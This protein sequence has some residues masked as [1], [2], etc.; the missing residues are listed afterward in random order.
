MHVCARPRVPVAIITPACRHVVCVHHDLLLLP[1][2]NMPASSMYWLV[3]CVGVCIDQYITARSL[4]SSFVLNHVLGNIRDGKPQDD[5]T[6]RDI[7]GW[8]QNDNSAALIH[9]LTPQ[10]CAPD[11]GVHVRPNLPDHPTVCLPT[12]PRSYPAIMTTTRRIRCCPCCGHGCPMR[13]ARSFVRL[14]IQPRRRPPNVS[15]KAAP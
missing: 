8:I 14:V 4:R 6:M 11:L 13:P 10:G 5:V 2:V 7:G 15:C 9:Y 12:A 1:G 3:A